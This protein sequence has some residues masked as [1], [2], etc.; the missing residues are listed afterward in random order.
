MKAKAIFYR[1]IRACPWVKELYLLP[2]EY[3]R[4]GP[5]GMSA[6]HL[7]GIYDLMVEKELRIHVD[8]DDLTERREEPSSQSNALF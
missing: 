7:R 4:D 5:D 8:L 3:L 2:F 1:A 6:A